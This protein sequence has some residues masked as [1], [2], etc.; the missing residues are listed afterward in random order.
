[1]N[2]DE[3]KELV[4]QIFLTANWLDGNLRD[5]LKRHGITVQQ[6]HVLS[7][8]HTSEVQ[9]NHTIIK[10]AVAQKDADISRLVNRLIHLKLINKS[11]VVG[12]K[13]QNR[14]RLSAKGVELMNVLQDIPQK[15]HNLFDHLDQDD[16]Q[17]LIQLLK[18]SHSA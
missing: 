2:L 16:T 17:D 12:D 1:M 4:Y 9:V 6:Y 7:F 10:K 13:R 14:L 11:A 3:N 8:I 5:L 15:I 18:K